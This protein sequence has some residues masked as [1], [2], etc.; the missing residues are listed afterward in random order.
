MYDNLPPL[1]SLRAFEAA[2]RHLS[3]TKAAREL[4]VTQG[5]VSYQ[6][7][8]LEERLDRLLFVRRIRAVTLT[9]EGS[10]LFEVCQRT[11]QDLAQEI[12]ALSPE[13]D[14]GI[15]IVAVSTYVTTR[16]LSRRLSPFFE[17]HPGTT[18][19]LQHSINAPDFSIEDVDIAIRWGQAGKLGPRSRTLV[20]TPMLP[21]CAPALMSGERAI[22]SPSDLQWHHLLRDEP[23]ED[24]WPDWLALA[25]VP[26]LK[27]RAGQTISDPNVR[28]QAAIDGQ[29]VVL[30]DALVADDIAEG[31]LIAPFNTAIEGYGYHLLWS[32]RSIARPGVRA[33]RDWLSALP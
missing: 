19:R 15:L 8:Q 13:R 14:D 25:G 2:A 7:R 11:F 20:P 18:L 27:T 6:I 26:G 12:A 1:H 21:L 5:A 30:A 24:L 31:R 16:W 9:A 17:A 4:H 33:F 23:G 29:G 22:K 32:A 3:F 28:V 10:R